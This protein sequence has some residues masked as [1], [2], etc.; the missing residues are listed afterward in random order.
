[1]SWDKNSWL[2]SACS[3][4]SRALSWVHSPV[5][6]LQVGVWIVQSANG[7]L[8]NYSRGKHLTVV[9]T[10]LEISVQ[11]GCSH[12]NLNPQ[13][14]QQRRQTKD[15]HSHSASCCRHCVTSS[16]ALLLPWF[17]GLHRLYLL[18]QQT[19]RNPS[20]LKFLWSGIQSQQ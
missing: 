15:R 17:Q 4:L 5:T 1:M 2:E 7:Q 16:P 20:L 13:C 18:K 14:Y 19:K 3:A 8:G 6:K 10:A 9:G 11:H 12:R